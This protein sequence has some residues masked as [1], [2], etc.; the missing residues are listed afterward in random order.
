MPKDFQ[1]PAPLCA[2]K[3]ATLGFKKSDGVPLSAVFISH[4]YLAARGTRHRSFAYINK[5]R[6]MWFKNDLLS[7]L[8]FTPIHEK[9]LYL[10]RFG[11]ANL[12]FVPAAH[13]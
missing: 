11:N 7:G 10:H 4:D 9:T 3:I 6:S 8:F 1:K 12:S 13:Q 5:Q 2:K